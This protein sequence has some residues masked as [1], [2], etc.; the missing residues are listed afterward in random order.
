MQ[1]AKH[2]GNANFNQGYAPVTQTGNTLTVIVS[3]TVSSVVLFYFFTIAAYYKK[4][5]KQ[6]PIVE[7]DMSRIVPC[8]IFS[9]SRND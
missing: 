1:P 3:Q 9:Y 6:N 2:A 5:S 4:Q 7:V 8:H